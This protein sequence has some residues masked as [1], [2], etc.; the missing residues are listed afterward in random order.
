LAE[1]IGKLGKKEIREQRSENEG[2]TGAGQIYFGVEGLT[3]EKR[4]G[5]ITDADNICGWFFRPHGAAVFGAVFP[6]LRPAAADLS[7][8]IVLRSLW[9][10]A[11]RG[12]AAFSDGPAF[13][14]QGLKPR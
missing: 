9:E 13:S 2:L 3:K 11:I 5:G 14:G 1:I 4:V 8:A 10:L 12:E 7:W 6:G